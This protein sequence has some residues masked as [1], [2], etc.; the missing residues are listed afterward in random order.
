MHPGELRIF[1]PNMHQNPKKLKRRICP[2]TGLDISMQQDNS[3]FLSAT[4]VEWYYNNKPETYKT[5]LAPRLR[6]HWNKQDIKIQFREIAH[7][8]RDEDSN[9][10]HST[11]RRIQKI[12]AEKNVLF[13]NAKL[14]PKDKLKTAGLI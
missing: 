7:L 5:T 11:R 2:V 1:H 13:D 8:I 4:G 3:K 12:L 9:K 10:R 14:I 6:D